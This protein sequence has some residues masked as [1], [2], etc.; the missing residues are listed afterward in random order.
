MSGSFSIGET[1]VRPGVYFR[2]E[3]SGAMELPGITS[4]VVGVAFKAN[5]GP[6]GQAVEL[7]SI[8]EIAS[9]YGDDSG[10]GSNVAVLEKVFMGGASRI[11]AVRVGAGGTKASH[12]LKDTTGTPVEVVTLTAK[13]AGTRALSVTIKDSLAD[14]RSVSASSIPARKSCA[15]CCSPRATQE[16]LMPW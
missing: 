12:K 6:L 13:H 11:Q 7:K 2:S 9:V 5:W 1:K 3:K 14:T 4:G 8:S 10:T 16:R 15:R